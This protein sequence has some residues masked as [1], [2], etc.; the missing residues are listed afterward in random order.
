M[1]EGARQKGGMFHR[2]YVSGHSGKIIFNQLVQPWLSVKQGDSNHL[3]PASQQH[4]TEHT[5]THI[6]RQVISQI[7][8]IG[9]NK[10]SWKSIDE[11][12]LLQVHFESFH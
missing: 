3:P 11:N 10:V 4:V 8:Y 12:L 1:G 6:W 9:K 7:F 5:Q 2:A